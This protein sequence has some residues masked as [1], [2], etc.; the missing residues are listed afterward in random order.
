MSRS[1][2]QVFD[3]YQQARTV[4]VQT[5]AELAHRPQ[6]IEALQNADVMALLRPL[7]LDTVP[8]IQQSAALALG[9][10]ANYSEALAEAV[11]MN[12]VLP[13]LVYSLADNNRF[14]KKTAAFV[15]KA[16]AKHSPEL[17]Q[18]VVDSGALPA[19]TAC[20]SEFEPSVKESAA[21]ALGYISQH[22]LQLAQSV[23]DAGA[24]A[25]LVLCLQEPE[26]S[27]KRIAASTLGEI[28]KHSP[29]LS[30]LLVDAGAI[31]FLS[32]LIAHPD[33]K[34]KRQVCSAL[35]QVAKH[36]V[37]LAEIV[38]ESEIFP[39]VFLCLQDPDALIKR[40]AATLI[41]E[42]SKHTPELAQLIV[43]AGGHTALIQY[44]TLPT[45]RG[46]ARLPALM[47][48]GYIGAFSETLATSIIVAQGL[49]PLR[50]TLV[51]GDGVSEEDHIK[52]AAVWSLGQIGRHTP[53][54]AKAIAQS[55]ILRLL[56]NLH[57]SPHSSTDLKLKCLRTLQQ[58]LQKTTYLPALE[59]LLLS[60]DDSHVLAALV[61]QFAKVLPNAPAG[62]KSFVTSR[63][64]AKVQELLWR[65]KEREKA[66]GGAVDVV[67]GGGEKLSES[68]GEDG[69][70]GEVVMGEWINIINT[71][72]PQEI[73]QFYSPNYAQTLIE[74][75]GDS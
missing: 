48:L 18:A 51:D 19:L 46:A 30:Q 74:K 49:L 36:S 65:E 16:V 52:A 56:I 45:V 50:S 58:L 10:L 32:P 39:K 37:D 7:L 4:F 31:A 21:W 34:L 73:V 25:P 1:V 24:I 3:A 41:R 40:H 22:T 33:T 67:S 55:D 28:A 38:V 59:P 13:Q 2:L 17:A 42:I 57:T 43:N 64:L 27:L 12:D 14:Y 44:L 47:T 35:S 54:H 69:E 63:G 5:V 53:D 8:S 15:L 20:L 70:S 75:L 68:G 60:T 61:Q 9:R 72:Y 11:V 71:C 66:G 29:E 6:N 62:R 26:L 23:V